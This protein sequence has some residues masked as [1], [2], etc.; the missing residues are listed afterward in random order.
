VERVDLKKQ[1]SKSAMK[2]SRNDGKRRVSW[3]T[4]DELKKSADDVEREEVSTTSANLAPSSPAAPAQAGSPT[5][6][7][8]STPAEAPGEVPA[9]EGDSPPSNFDAVAPVAEPE[10][11]SPP[12]ANP[13][14]EPP[15]EPGP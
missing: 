13:L 2:S 4:A 7:L 10:D 8:V 14:E 11:E 12:A 9:A 5:V 3:I 15:E 1:P 6:V